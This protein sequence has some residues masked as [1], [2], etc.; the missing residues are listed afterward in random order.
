MSFVNQYRKTSI[1]SAREDQLDVI[2]VND[3]ENDTEFKPASNLDSFKSKTKKLSS[4]NSNQLTKK[5][6]E[7][8]LSDLECN[9]QNFDGIELYKT[10]IWTRRYAFVVLLSSLTMIGYGISTTIYEFVQIAKFDNSRDQQLQLA[11]EGDQQPQSQQLT[12][13]FNLKTFIF[14]QGVSLLT[15]FITLAQGIIGLILAA[16][17]IVALKKIME[18]GN[19]PRCLEQIQKKTEKIGEMMNLLVFIQVTSAVAYAAVYINVINKAQEKFEK[20]ENV[21]FE[22]ARVISKFE[23]II[24][25]R[26]A[27]IIIFYVLGCTLSMLAFNRFKRHQ[28]RYEDILGGN[29][30]ILDNSQLYQSHKANNAILEE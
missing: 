24:T 4:G 8:Q 22:E 12:F 3:F 14:L 2:P 6:Q 9:N 23:Q 29:K 21:N 19:N 15:S 25:V 5:G 17:S 20:Q 26:C 28:K 11:N 27:F 1:D 10:Q 30:A 13:Q 18:N 7:L 16:Q